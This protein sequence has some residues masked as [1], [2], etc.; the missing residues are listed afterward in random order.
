MST[1]ADQPGQ[2]VGGN[3]PQ[4]VVRDVASAMGYLPAEITQ[5]NLADVVRELR[6]ILEGPVAHH[7]M[8][9]GRFINEKGEVT[10]LSRSLWNELDDTYVNE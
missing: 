5:E 7:I 2:D 9:M 8:E 4:M 10:R 1:R 6:E 3:H